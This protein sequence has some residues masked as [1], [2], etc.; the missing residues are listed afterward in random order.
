M[1]Q[2]RKMN[3]K[4]WLFKI[5]L[6]PVCPPN[7]TT[8]S[9]LEKLQLLTWASSGVSACATPT[10]ANPSEQKRPAPTPQP[11]ADSKLPP[12]CSYTA[13]HCP[14]ASPCNALWPHSTGRNQSLA[15]LV[16]INWTSQPPSSKEK[17]HRNPDWGFDRVEERE[18]MRKHNLNQ[19]PSKEKQIL[20]ARG[21]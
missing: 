20:F 13:V 11:H 2:E 10:P 12:F 8:K 3:I 19:W 5:T 15:F 17:K 1:I 16:L 9:F 21:T 4:C 6:W 18:G 7:D 14:Q